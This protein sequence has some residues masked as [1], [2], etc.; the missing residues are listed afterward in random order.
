[1]TEARGLSAARGDSV[2]KTITDFATITYTNNNPDALDVLW[3]HFDKNGV[4]KQRQTRLGR[5]GLGL[6]DQG[7]AEEHPPLRQR[8]VTSTLIGLPVDKAAI[9]F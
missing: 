7:F 4:V 6:L 2:I 3:R 1:M 8:G 9:N 5:V